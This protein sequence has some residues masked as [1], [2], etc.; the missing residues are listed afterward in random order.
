[1]T[2]Q[3]MTDK[4]YKQWVIQLKEKIGAAQIKAS[5][6]VNRQLLELYWELGEGDL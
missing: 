3:L 2:Q 5:L 1:M 6:T 4:V